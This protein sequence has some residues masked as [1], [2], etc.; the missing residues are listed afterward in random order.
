[1]RPYGQR[2]RET[3]DEYL[4]LPAGDGRKWRVGSL[5]R[6]AKEMKKKKRKKIVELRQ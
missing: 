4:T 6:M 5:R 1:M 3:P 2:E